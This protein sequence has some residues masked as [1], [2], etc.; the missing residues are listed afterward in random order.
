VSVIDLIMARFPVF[1]TNSQAAS[2]FGP[3]EPSA[4]PRLLSVCGVGAADRPLR[5]RP[6]LC[7]SGVDVGHDR[8][9]IGLVV[10]REQST[11]DATAALKPGV[12]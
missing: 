11:R 3:I 8:Q 10:N 1:S 4:K 6:L 9:R 5:R 2:T 7:V 12:R